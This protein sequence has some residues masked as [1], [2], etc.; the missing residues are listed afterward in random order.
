VFGYH[1]EVTTKDKFDISF[2]FKCTANGKLTDLVHFGLSTE[3]VVVQGLD[4]PIDVKMVDKCS[5]GTML[6]L[7][8]EWSLD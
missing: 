8:S 6:D 2:D 3:D 5:M 7:R 4:A 1:V